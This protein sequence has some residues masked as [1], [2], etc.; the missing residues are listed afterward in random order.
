[1]RS[2]KILCICITVLLLV[3]SFS[4]AFPMAD[5]EG[6]TFELPEGLTITLPSE[7]SEVT[8][9]DMSEA[10]DGFVLNADAPPVGADEGNFFV[11]VHVKDAPSD[12]TED[13]FIS[14]VPTNEISGPENLEHLE[15]LKNGVI[16]S[17]DMDLY[18]TTSDLTV[19]FEGHARYKIRS[20]KY[21]FVSEAGKLYEIEI[22]ITTSPKNPDAP[23][24]DEDLAHLD[25]LE[26]Y[27]IGSVHFE[28]NTVSIDAGAFPTEGE[29][30]NGQQGTEPSETEAPET[31]APKKEKKT[32][33][34]SFTTFEFP[35]WLIA[36]GMMLLLFLGAKVSKRHEWLEEPLSLSTSKG[37][38][39]F[40][41]V[42][43][44]LHHLSQELVDKAGPLEFLSGCGVLFVGIFFFFSGYGLYTSLKNKE[45]YLKGF[46]KKRYVAILVPFYMCILV[47]TLALCTC[48]TKLKGWEI[49][50]VLSGW[51]LINSH[52]WY[53]VE[54]AIL[55]LVFFIIYR[56]IKNRTVATILMTVF[57]LAMMGGS[58]WLCHGKDFSCK[59]WFMG[60]WWYNASFLFIV[61][62]LVSKHADILAKIA[63]KAYV[64]L[65]PVF[66]GLTWFL[67]VMT[68]D[69]L[70]KYS[71]WSEIP[72]ETRAIGDKLRCLSVQLPWIMCFVIFM[73]LV[74]MKVRFGNPVLKFLGS[75]SME[76][77][78][79]HNLFLV[80][81]RDGSIFQVSSS[82]MY[83]LLTVLLAVGMATI[84]SGLDKYIIALITG[85]KREDLKLKLSDSSRIHSIDVMRGVMAFLVVAI[86]WPFDGKA[87]DVFITF[88]KTA[89]PF[90]LVVC[91]Y[92]LFRED[93]GE[94]MQ[95]LKKQ[96]KRIFLFFVLS[97][98]F[99]C[100]M[101][102]LYSNKMS[103]SWEEFKACFKT[104]SLLN[105]LLYNFSPFSEHLWY[106]G[107]LLY[108]LLI[109]M[110][111]NKLKVLKYAMYLAPALVAAYVVL[112]HMGVGEF[113]QLRNALF[114][115]L[116]YTMMG[117]LIRRYEKKILC[118]KHI[119]AVLLILFA[120]CSFAAVYELNHYK[121][122]TAV[123]FIGAEIMTYVIVLLCLRFP[124]FGVGTFAE[125]FGRECSLP[126]YIMHIAVMQTLLMTKNDLFFGRIGAV[127]IFVIT[128]FI[129]A[130]YESVKKAVSTTKEKT[131]V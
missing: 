5:E 48:G 121:Q 83:I 37:I 20:N 75:I 98:V 76:L 101:Y 103:G 16:R 61:G 27:I 36:C 122:G 128:A 78:L 94:M 52:M 8:C 25:Y 85:K 80:G 9:Y 120:V 116:G 17:G 70:K 63:K 40:A 89:V 107:S 112:A 41:A 125:R 1:M 99:Y 31:T 100:G 84:V 127:T 18:K 51:T 33:F 11:M 44:I 90:F 87:G 82:S 39:G 106:L 42:A 13:I 46:L 21:S 24:N 3:V 108:A 86:H 65:L 95:R 26:N 54:I 72:G 64:V 91:G 92:L 45:N 88:G 131:P 130:A 93:T 58:L 7:F 15:I 23:F 97:N 79:L 22:E 56:L 118:I 57:V 117:M 60:E 47:F 119:G 102:A 110:L 10:D 62:I 66:A 109:L 2:R 14:N 129:V 111:L 67:G 69:T 96:T 123:P 74:M 113:Y 53:I 6:R 55:Y 71:Y 29:E 73:L 30:N 32:F 115:G 49:L 77:Y 4:A 28:G 43:I 59:Y 81:L 124:D 68:N 114:I 19:N 105:F 104:K 126:I 35:I 12:I 38:Q 50:R 34:Q